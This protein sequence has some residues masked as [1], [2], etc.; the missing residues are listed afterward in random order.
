MSG[1][2]GGGQFRGWARLAAALYW[3]ARVLER[4]ARE[5]DRCP[6]CGRFRYHGPPCRKNEAEVLEARAALA[7]RA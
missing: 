2:E 3:A 6:E 1:P 4:A 5:V 7:R